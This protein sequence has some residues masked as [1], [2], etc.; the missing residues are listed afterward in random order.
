VDLSI[1]GLRHHVL[2]DDVPEAFL[3]ANNQDHREI[4]RNADK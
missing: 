1:H 3:V 4:R 2:D